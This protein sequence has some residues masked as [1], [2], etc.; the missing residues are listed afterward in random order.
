[1]KNWRTLCCAAS[2]EHSFIASFQQRIKWTEDEDFVSQV[3]L[4]HDS[5]SHNNAAR[6]YFQKKMPESMLAHSMIESGQLLGTD[7]LM[8]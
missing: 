6:L 3:E 1:M 4:F 7:T 2:L 8:G 5:C